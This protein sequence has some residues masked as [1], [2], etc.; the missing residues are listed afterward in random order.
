ML[1]KRDEH[2][3]LFYVVAHEKLADGESFARDT[4]HSDQECVGSRA[5]RKPCRFGIEKRPALGRRAGDFVLAQSVEKIGGKF[6]ERA[7][8]GSAVL[9]VR[10]IG[11]LHLKVRAGIV[12]DHL[13]FSPF[14]DKR[15]SQPAPVR[16]V[17]GLRCTRRARI[18]IFP[19]N[20]RNPFAQPRELLFNIQHSLFLCQYSDFRGRRI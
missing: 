16:I 13:P 9:P 1:F 15:A 8:I 6:S 17:S 7:N 12:R 5:A 10:R 2:A 20:R 18:L 4:A 19:V 3:A 14:F 11:A